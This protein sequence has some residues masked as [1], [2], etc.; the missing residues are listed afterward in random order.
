MNARFRSVVMAMIVALVAG[1]VSVVAPSTA[2]A[3]PPPVRFVGV[4]ETSTGA[5][6]PGI[7]VELLDGDGDVAGD[8]VTDSAGEYAITYL[9][10]GS[11]DYSYPGY[12][13]RFTDPADVYVTQFWDLESVQPGY[14]QVFGVVLEVGGTLS[15]RFVDADGDPVPDLCLTVPDYTIYLEFCAGADGR[16]TTGKLVPGR[17]QFYVSGSATAEPTEF[18]GTVVAGTN[19]LVGD[20]VVETT[21]SAGGTFTIS[22]AVTSAD[23]GNLVPACISVYGSTSASA[24][25]CTDSAGYYETPE[26]P[27]GFYSLWVRPTDGRH[28]PVSRFVSITSAAVVEDFAVQLGASLSGRVTAADGTTPI[29]GAEVVV[30]QQASSCEGES[31][32]PLRLGSAVTAADGTYL[33]EGLYGSS[34]SGAFV[35][36]QAPGRLGQFWD[37]NAE[38]PHVGFDSPSQAAPI[39]L[40]IGATRANVDARLDAVT[41]ASISGV[42]TDSVSDAPIVGASVRL[43][44]ASPPYLRLRTVA[45]DATGSYTFVDVEPGSYR[46]TAT[47]MGYQSET[48]DDAKLAGGT[49]VQVPIAAGEARTG[50]SFALDPQG[51]ISGRVSANRPP[52]SPTYSFFAPSYCVTATPVAPAFDPISRCRPFGTDYE[53]SKLP[54]GTYDLTIFSGNFVTQTIEDVVVNAPSRTTQDAT[55]S[56][57][58]ILSGTVRND[59][60]DPVSFVQVCALTAGCAMADSDG[61]YQLPVVPGS[62]ALRA[63]TYA[64]GSDLAPTYYP[65]LASAPVPPNVVVTDDVAGLDITMIARPVIEVTVTSGGSTVCDATVTATAT[66]GSPWPLSFSQYSCTGGMYRL[67]VDPGTYTVRVSSPL[68]APNKYVEKFYDNASSAAGAT[69]IVLTGGD[70]ETLAFDVVT[71]PQITGVVTGSDTGNPPLAGVFVQASPTSPG[72][73]S[74]ATTGPDGSYTVYM[75]AG[76]Y[77]LYFQKTGYRPEWWD[78]KTSFPV[79]PI[80]VTTGSVTANAELL[81]LASISGRVTSSDPSKPVVGGT[82]SAQPF[83]GIGSVVSAFIQPNGNYTMFVEPGDYR[84]QFSAGITFVSEWWNDK[85]SAMAAD[86]VTATQAGTTGIDAVLTPLVTGTISGTV[87]NNT[88]APLS[89]I[90]IALYDTVGT[91][92][93][94]STGT[95]SFGQY[96]FTLPLGSYRLQAMVFSF[97][98]GP[99]PTV[100][101]EYYDNKPDLAS[102]TVVPLTSPTTPVTANFSLDPA[103]GPPGVP[104]SVWATPGP[105]SVSLSWMQLDN[106]Q[107]P[108]LETR[109]QK[110]TDGG[111]T[112]SWAATATGTATSATA[113]GLTGGVGHQFR[114]RARNVYGWGPWSS[115]VSAIPNVAP[116]PPSQPTSVVATPST[117]GAIRVDLAWTISSPS[118]PVTETRV[119]KSTDGGAT[120]TWAATVTGSA[121]TA[122]ASGLTNGTSYVFR[123]RSQNAWGFGPWSTPT[124]AVT[125]TGTVGPPGPI[126][127]GSVTPGAASAAL[128]WSPPTAGGGTISDIRIQKSTDNGVTWTWAATPS[129]SATTA[130]VTG[131][132]SGTP[133]RFRMRALNE[134]G[135][136]PWSATT[137]AVTPT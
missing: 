18:V 71:N 124:A 6:L 60:G 82:V 9:T 96:S 118:S 10:T 36:F 115:P 73:G 25:V 4:V 51:S 101:G 110:S 87:T 114:L 102:A 131:L 62:Y 68:Q 98:G 40:V 56:R 31:Q 47:A 46:V 113:T 119:Q 123:L 117:T 83:S 21:T 74:G 91:F 38:P 52:L 12:R 107:S 17:T 42:V 1:A 23:D 100:R 84:L 49:I 41:P 57:L 112:W 32:V 43:Y 79:D 97:P 19:T 33:I 94:S 54:S 105:N 78:N 80:T 85:A 66:T 106:G 125:P 65:S 70:F 20:I 30:C 77:N 2:T 63:Q 67:L 126:T 37:G 89:G 108:I 15:G 133:H 109:A 127:I 130:T 61:F 137:A 128:N 55:L 92:Q 58:P 103:V 44:R 132:T 48:Y 13:L 45:T 69:P 121:T 75:P 76:T 11:I 120:W 3:A 64:L 16:F 104:T 50:V 26:L 99:P 116:T 14:D 88:G 28:L 5:P 27:A 136:G 34:W 95:N 72:S 90:T 22:G 8:A 39:A 135:W 35:A 111:A 53:I 129:P 122:T 81:K 134:A 93:I 24:E 59:A 86:P 29:A 7:A